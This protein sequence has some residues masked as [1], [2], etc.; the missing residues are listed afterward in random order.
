[1]LG[2]HQRCIPE[3]DT[4]GLHMPTIKAL[5]KEQQGLYEKK[6]AILPSIHTTLTNIVKARFC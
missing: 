5:G 3:D 6:K 1:M 4:S 2:S